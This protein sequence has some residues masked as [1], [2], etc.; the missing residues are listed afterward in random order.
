M[1]NYHDPTPR[2][3]PGSLRRPR[4]KRPLI[5]LTYRE[6]RLTAIH[7][8]TPAVQFVRLDLTAPVNPDAEAAD[9]PIP[10]AARQLSIPLL[11]QLPPELH[12][13]AQRAFRCS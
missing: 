8:S 11:A 6:D 10:C 12:L 13:A 5:V 9:F 7:S 4:F 2:R 3:H 1:T